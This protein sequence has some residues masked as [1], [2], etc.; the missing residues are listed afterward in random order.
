MPFTIILMPADVSAPQPHYKMAIERAI[1][2]NGGQIAPHG[3]VR[4]TDGGQFVVEN[5]DFWLKR[6][7]PGVCREIR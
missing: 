5:N 2:A 6:L 1:E 4:L 3:L 7:T